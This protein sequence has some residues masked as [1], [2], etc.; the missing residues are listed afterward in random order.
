MGTAQRLRLAG[1]KLGAPAAEYD[2]WVSAF[3]VVQLLRLRAQVD[4]GAAAL[5]HPNR[6]DVSTL[7]H[8]DRRLLKEALRVARQLQQR[9]QLDWMR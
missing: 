2:G 1:A 8:I 9:V 5:A 4:A 3:D 6:L 7:N